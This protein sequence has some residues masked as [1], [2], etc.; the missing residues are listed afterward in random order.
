MSRAIRF[1]SIEEPHMDGLS[2]L[3]VF[4]DTANDDFEEL[5]LGSWEFTED[6]DD[7]PRILAEALEGTGWRLGQELGTS[8]WTILR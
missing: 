6:P 2:E 8:L 1:I 5:E 3:R 7:A 4:T